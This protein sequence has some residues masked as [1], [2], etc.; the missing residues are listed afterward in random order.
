MHAIKLILEKKLELRS[1]ELAEVNL[2]ALSDRS[3]GVLSGIT[4]KNMPTQTV[5]DDKKTFN[6]PSLNH[7]YDKRNRKHRLATG[8]NVHPET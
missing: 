6:S 2:S 1:R 7:T 4:T 8:K 3:A 5:L